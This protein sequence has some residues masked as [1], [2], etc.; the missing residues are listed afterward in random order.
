[1]ANHYC[2]DANDIIPLL[3]SINTVPKQPNAVD[4]GVN[5]LCTLALYQLRLLCLVRFWALGWRGR[6]SQAEAVKAEIIYFTY[7]LLCCCPETTFSERMIAFISNAPCLGDA[8][9]RCY[10]NCTC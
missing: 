5:I 1:M 6:S 4:C 8:L 9:A 7:S 3:H 2:S 10:N